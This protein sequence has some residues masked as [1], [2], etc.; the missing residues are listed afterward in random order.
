MV[1]MALF[2]TFIT[3]PTVMAVYNYKAGHS[4]RKLEDL[5][6]QVWEQLRVVACV[7]GPSN[8]PSIINLMESTRSKWPVKLF[9][10]HLVELTERSSSILLAQRARKNGLPFFNSKWHEHDPLA[11]Y[12]QMG[13]VKVRPTTAIS[14]LTTMHEDICHVAEEKRVAIIILPFHK[15]WI[16]R[17]TETEDDV[18]ENNVGHGWRGVNQRVLRD[19]PCSVGVLVDRGSLMSPKSNAQN[20]CVLYFGGPD[21]EEALELGGRM[22]EHPAVKVTLIRFVEEEEEYDWRRSKCKWGGEYIE[23]KVGSKSEIVEQVMEIGT[24]GGFHLIVVG[25]GHQFASTE[26]QTQ[27]QRQLPPP[28]HPE[29]G[30]IGDILAS[31]GKGF[32]SSVLVIQQHH[33]HVPH[34]HHQHQHQ[35]SLS[36]LI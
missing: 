23:K 26:T 12:S 2:T 10:M 19:A 18:E 6:E 15:Q 24:S 14:S 4:K 28:E 20:V 9:I 32:K 7:H 30:P 8:V 5:K 31:S 35:P 21:D 11:G 36:N 13:R 29:L 3:T 34:H 33:L 1:L 17:R 25:K 16:L 27:T 22:A